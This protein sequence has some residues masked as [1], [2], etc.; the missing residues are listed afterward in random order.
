M[1]DDYYKTLG[2]SRDATADEIQKAYRNLARKYHPDVNPDDKAAQQKFKEVQNAYDVVGD[3]EKR[4]K[5]DQFGPQFEQMG[6]GGAGPGGGQYRTWTGG[7]PGGATYQYEGD[8]DLGDIF[9]S[10]GGEPGGGF[11]E[12]FRHFT[13]GAAGAQQSRTRT[14]RAGADIQHEIEV[15]FQTA[16]SGGE[17]QLNVIRDD[18]ERETI[19]AKIPKG[20]EDGKKI[21][22]RGQGEPGPRGGPAGDLIITVRVAAHPHFRRVGK[23]LEVT[24]PVTLLEAAEGAKVDIPTPRGTITLTVP[25]GTS[26]GRKLRLKGMGV[27]PPKGDAG[28]L[29]AEIQVMIP[30]RLSPEELEQIRQIDAR[31]RMSPRGDLRW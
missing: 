17:V 26:S 29:L 10:A 22:L 18:G 27:E 9:G 19:T 16:V 11:S 7:G 6:A 31:H 13:G 8:V 23:N 2:V 25:Q 21:R 4:K 1:A 28:D 12:F 3:P 24:V 14:P 20:I 5:Y 30:D 15:P